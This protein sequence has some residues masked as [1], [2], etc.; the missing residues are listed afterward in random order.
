M[1]APILSFTAE[2]AWKDLH[3]GDADVPSIFTELFHDIP[4]PDDALVLLQK[5]TR[6]REIRADVMREIETVR[7]TG[8]VGSSLAAELDVYATGED[9]KLLASLADDLRFVLIVSRATLHQGEDSLR[10]DVQPTKAPKCERCWHHRDDVGQDPEH[11]GLCGRCV[12]NL[13]GTGEAR[14]HA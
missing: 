7:A 2:E 6:L 11:P 4:Q 14:E 1:L 10:I 13:F 12:S 9:H 8:E 5:W 3:R